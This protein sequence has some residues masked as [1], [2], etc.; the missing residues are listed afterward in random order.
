MC[1]DSNRLEWKLQHFPSF[2]WSK[3]LSVVVGVTHCCCRV[4][5]VSYWQIDYI[6]P[7]DS[8]T[9]FWL[10]S[11]D[12]IEWITAISSVNKYKINRIAWGIK[13]AHNIRSQ[14]GKFRF[15][16]NLIEI[17]TRIQLCSEA[18][19][20]TKIFQWQN[21][22]FSKCFQL[23]IWKYLFNGISSEFHNEIE[24]NFHKR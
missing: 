13:R 15:V 8:K 21:M 11:F 17:R 23:C 24:I 4:S 19:S 20:Q 7:K 5:P 3:Y 2:F 18:I 1:T 9:C 10:M 14:E 22:W 6:V 12:S 16:E